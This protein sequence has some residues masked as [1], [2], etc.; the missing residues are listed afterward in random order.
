[1]TIVFDPPRAAAAPPKP[2]ARARALTLPAR[3]VSR[4]NEAPALVGFRDGAKMDDVPLVC[5]RLAVAASVFDST[6]R[7]VVVGFFFGVRRSLSVKCLLV[8]AGG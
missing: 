5:V 4:K 2:L 6:P 7:A 8:V 1:M 3:P